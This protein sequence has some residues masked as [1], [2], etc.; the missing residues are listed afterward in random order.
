MADSK[1]GYSKA[2]K[3]YARVMIH[4]SMVDALR[5]YKSKVRESL[6]NN[7]WK[8]NMVN[9]NDVV[10]TY[11]PG[12]KGKA[13]GV[14]YKFENSRYIVVADM[15]SGYL[16]IYDKKAKSYTTANGTPSKDLRLTHFK[17]KK[18]KEMP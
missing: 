2:A 10:N 5:Y 1:A 9:L 16:R 8:K 13:K 18:R 15:P 14:K 3:F 7:D 6:Y 4:G 12:V 17:I 11:T